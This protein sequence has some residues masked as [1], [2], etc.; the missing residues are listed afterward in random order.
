MEDN[1]LTKEFLIES[2]ENLGRLDQE[3]V[4][5]EQ[6][7]KDATL[8]ASIFRII[9]TL[10][11]TCGF[12][13]FSTIER[14]TH[15]TETIL[16]QVR[17]GERELTPAIVSLVLQSVDVVKVE[18]AAIEETQAESGD[19]Y[20]DLV[21]HL[22][23]VAATLNEEASEPEATGQT[24]P[25]AETPVSTAAE[26]E[27]PARPMAEPEG[28]ARIVADIE[29][30]PVQEKTA[31]PDTAAKGPSVADSTIRVDVG[32]LDRLM[33]LVGELVL[34]RNQVLQFTSRLEDASLTATSQRLNLITSELQEG[35]MKTR[36]QPIGVVWNKL[37]RVVRDLSS[38][39]GKQINLEM[40]GA[41]TELDKTIIEAI[42]DPL[43]HIVRNACDHGIENAETRVQSGKS[44]AGRLALRAFH[45]GGNVNIEI[46]DDGNG[47][48]T[49]RVKAKALQQGL[50][51]EDQAERM[52]EREL[53]NLVFMPGFSTAKE[54]TSI[55]GRGVGMDVVKTNIEKIGGTVDLVSRPGTG[56]TIRI[57]IPLT[58]AIIPGLVVSVREERFVIPQTSLLELVRLEG[59][60]SRRLIQWVG[61]SPLYRRRGN[62]LPLVFLDRV[63]QL[64]DG[65]GSVPDV[66]N[67][68]V[69]QAEDRQFGLV[70]DGV[71]DTQEIVVKPLG[72]QMK[73]LNCYAGA[74]IMG[75]GRVALILDVMGVAQRSGVLAEGRSSSRG[76]DKFTSDSAI[77]ARDSMLLF[78][79]GDFQRLAVPL[80][81]VARLEEIPRDRL[82]YAAGRPVVQYRGQLLPLVGLAGQ[83]GVHSE[84]NPDLPVQVIVF[85]DGDNRI[86]MIVDEIVDIVEDE[87]VIRR[88]SGRAGILGS[89]VIGNEVTDVL[90]LQS[91]I[92][93]ADTG[94]FE[95]AQ[96]D[97]TLRILVVEGSA[98]S[99]GLLRSSLEMGGYSISEASDV[100]EAVAKLSAHRFDLILAALDLPNDGAER[101]IRA[102]HKQPELARIPIVAVQPLQHLDSA[103][104]A[105][106]AGFSASLSRFDR[107]GMLRSI[108][109]L[110]KA[111][112]AEE[113]SLQPA[114][115]RSSRDFHETSR[116]GH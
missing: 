42:K 55:S 107:D 20:E 11:G 27:A 43:T 115:S 78:R 47:V 56:T 52:S 31:S 33:N 96:E 62:L 26:T 93:S 12:L 51:R 110:A 46:A 64:D 8:L 87:I 28:P 7:P 35:V 88:S 94:W 99:R 61:D 29:S 39:C 59:E 103:T 54:I 77:E 79:A 111:L 108:S 101:L 40:D 102:T 16:G 85:A 17:T 36:M 105:I 67:I 1:D 49:Q 23:A 98:F 19:Q 104:G 9:H 106:P 25:V 44:A 2:T 15:H 38:L 71:N 22:E 6:R 82:E 89:A 3:M 116:K 80:A 92:Q 65:C 48:N 95:S 109:Q 73:G 74:T 114:G 13:G 4:L 84:E 10:K 58:L 70:V 69:L 91:V 5:L 57:K 41:E 21:R 63:L 76:E 75:D 100:D 14:I 68:V 53:A 18:L 24:P 30:A 113:S 34:A 37:P 97:H 72:K 83:L 32:L 112:E 90:D 45:E 81:L 86:G 60:D 50:I 66:L